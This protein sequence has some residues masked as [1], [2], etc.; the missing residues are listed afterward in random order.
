MSESNT[1]T[2]VVTAVLTGIFTVVAGI[3]TYWITTKEPELAFT[4]ASGPSLPATGGTKRIFVVE[5][6]NSGKKE[7]AQTLIQLSLANGELSEV[8]SEASPGVRITQ[9]KAPKK[10]DINADLLNPGDLVKVSFLT[11]LSAPEAEPRVVVRAPGVSAIDQSKKKGFFAEEGKKDLPLLLAPALAAVLSTFL[12]LSRSSLAR[13]LGLPSVSNDLHQSEISSFICAS[14]QLDEEATLL[15]FGG[16]EI[17]YRGTADFLVHRARLASPHERP[18]YTTALRSL[19]MLRRI[20]E[21]TVDAIRFAIEKLSGNV[22][23][24][25]EFKALQKLAPTEGNDP[26]AWRK[27]VVT[28]AES[29]L[30]KANPALKPDSQPTGCGP[31]S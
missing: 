13:R 12:L 3:A 17:T 25:E 30:L 4:V 8:V 6:R 23:S 26:V 22:V 16:S 19:L 15:R 28:Y 1:K 10:I 7:I 14:C 9:E 27:A 31:A 24:D 21:S 5:V 11:A 29:Q 18:K 2:A 20:H